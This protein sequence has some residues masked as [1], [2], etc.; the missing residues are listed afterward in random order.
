MEINQNSKL[1]LSDRTYKALD[2]PGIG[3]YNN[4]ILE[5]LANSKIV[6]VFL[7]SADK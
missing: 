1:R 4:K 3:Y 5:S 2:I 7:D 6:L